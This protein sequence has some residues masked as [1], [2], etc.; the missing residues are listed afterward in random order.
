F[1]FGFLFVFAGDRV[2]GWGVFAEL[3]RRH[4]GFAGCQPDQ[5]STISLLQTARLA[6]QLRL[7]D[8]SDPVFR[9]RGVKEIDGVAGRFDRSAGGQRMSTRNRQN[10]QP[11]HEWHE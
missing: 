3:S 9:S 8:L 10:D 1:L 5:I 4:P 7:V 6:R 11:S 2:S